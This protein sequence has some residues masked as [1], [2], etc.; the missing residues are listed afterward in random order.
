VLYLQDLKQT[1]YDLLI[2]FHKHNASYLDISK[3][4][5]DKFLTKR[6]QDSDNDWKQVCDTY[7]LPVC[8]D[9]FISRSG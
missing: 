2:Q 4:Y 7:F 1:Y 5:L 6:M 9:E 3:A 8:D